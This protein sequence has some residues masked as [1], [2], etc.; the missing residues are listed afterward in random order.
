MAH[1]CP[2]DNAMTKYRWVDTHC[3]LQHEAFDADRDAVLERS[4]AE[5]DWIVVIG[6][7]VASSERGC[8]LVRAG[9]Y[10]TAGIHPHE[11]KH[12]DA[13]ALAAI[14]AMAR[15]ERVCAIGEIGLDYHYDFSPRADQRRAFA[16]QLDMAAR[17][18]LPV[19]IHCREAEDDLA[20]IIESA[21]SKPC[22]VM[23]CFGGD[24]A[25]AG[26]CLDWGLYVS[27]AGNATYPKAQPLREAAAVVPVERL[28]VETDSPY[29]APQP[30]RGKRCE[31]LHVR[32]TGEA[33]AQIKGIPPETLAGHIRENAMR[34][35]R[36]SVPPPSAGT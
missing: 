6:D 5:L 15:R 34:A 21:S 4:L 3:H 17:L 28:L 7:S 19:V 2:A 16:A 35:L 1:E 24:A 31:P 18:G 32:Y 30:L 13:A 23:H 36:L 20:A 26:R 33:V 25:F 29:L 9:V 22:G 10:A 14:E 27:F 12:A 8:G 11:A